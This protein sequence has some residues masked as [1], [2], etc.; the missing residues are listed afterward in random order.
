MKIRRCAGII[1]SVMALV[2]LP[3]VS[4]AQRTT[5]TL[6]TMLD[7][8]EP[9]TVVAIPHGIYEG[10][11]TVTK[12]LH[13]KGIPDENN[14]LP[15][16][17]GKGSGTVLT[18]TAADTTVEGFV[19]RGSGN[20]I[21]REDGG[22]VV[23]HAAN[24]RLLNNR[25]EDVLYG[26]RGVESNGLQIIGNQIGGKDLHIARRGDGLRIWQSEN[27]LV[28]GN[29]IE[30]ARD[31][32][33]WFSD[34]TTV[35]NNHF[36][37]SRYGVHMMYTDSM[38]IEGNEM[39]GNSVGAYL[40]YSKNVRINGNTFR[41]NRGPSGYGLALK[42]MDGVTVADNY[43]ID[44][45]VGIFFDNSPSRVDITQRVE[46]NVLAFNDVGVLM[47]PAVQH[48]Q[49]QD[50]TFL[51]NLEQVGLKG[52][53]S[54]PDESLGA[55]GWDGNY[56]SDY[57][58]YDAAGEG[59]GDIP[60][61]A[62]SL[63]ENLADQHPELAL[64]HFSPAEQAIDLAAE[65][66]PLIKPKPKLSDAVPRMTPLLPQAMPIIAQPSNAM[67][68]LA[69]LLL[70][71]AGLLYWRQWPTVAWG[72]ALVDAKHGA[73]MPAEK[74]QENADTRIVDYPISES[75]QKEIAMDNHSPTTEPMISVQNLTKRYAQPGRA[76]WSDATITAVD[77]LSFDLA[78]GQAVALWGVNGA[79]KTTVLKCLL[80]LLDCEGE[81]WLD[82]AD[83]RKD[84]RN[85]RRHFGYVP[86]ELAFH[87]DLSVVESCRFYARLKNV[88]LARV[89]LVLAQ[90][91]LA[92]QRRKAVGAL[93][94]GMKQ[95]L[96]LALALLADPPVL[97]LDEPTSNLDA[98]TRAGFLDLL[99][100]LH[101]AGKTLLFTSHHLEEV[102]QLA[103]RVLILRD[104]KLLAQGEPAELMH[105]LHP[106]RAG[107]R[108]QAGPI[109]RSATVSRAQSDNLT[110]V[111]TVRAQ[112]GTVVPTSSQQ[113]GSAAQ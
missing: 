104:G 77:D 45:R 23:E 11:I 31:A 28:E 12:P 76:W 89:P 55:N 10:A 35:R 83:L 100:A 24:V 62:V 22:I 91:G 49:L 78:Q 66:F 113:N 111:V 21:D 7:R 2:I 110:N 95:R 53:G 87:N 97:L 72:V 107:K 79:G 69:G 36:R 103:D 63:F 82:H 56:W 5:P 39:F 51:D 47:M 48:N 105:L 8:A 94:G 1:L 67:G 46:R 81:L 93:S 68:W 44:N 33:F 15:V 13:L 9:G 112:S 29:S 64:L 61:H 98:E 90:V 3:G 65:A 37:N 4:R 74:A 30:K 26:I 58:G 84:G 88:E 75:A 40:M 16:I 42:D 17:D 99:V 6:Q 108:V 34:G 106:K 25:L 50:N 73:R 20:V 41:E 57:V 43:Y 70:L 60:Y 71:S 59:T 19:I 86:Q 14:Q 101:H 54:N 32:I 18:I 85:A 102:E 96:A 52:G 109:E 92:D 80:G 38:T 27:C